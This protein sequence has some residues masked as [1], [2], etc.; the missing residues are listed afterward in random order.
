MILSPRSY[1]RSLIASIDPSR[2]PRRIV[3]L[4]KVEVDADDGR[5][6]FSTIAGFKGL[7]SDAVLLIDIDD[8]SSSNQAEL[9]YTGASRAKSLLALVLD[10]SC[11]PLYTER[12]REL[13]GR[14]IH[15]SDS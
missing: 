5:I 6:H 9:L 14:L 1:E 15:V 2:L 7:E 12:V 10:E 3:D 4:T 11:R 8:L 13:V